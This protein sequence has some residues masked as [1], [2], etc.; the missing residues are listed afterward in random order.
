VTALLMATAPYLVWY[1]QEAKM[2][3]ALTVLVPAALLLTV[4]VARRG[5]WWRWVLLYVI[6]SLAFYTHL[7]AALVVPIQALWLLLL[8]IASASG[9]AQTRADLGGQM[10]LRRGLA[11]AGYLSA[12]LLPY[13][14]L[15]MW[16]TRAWLGPAWETGFSFVSLPNILLVLAV[17]FSRG[18]LP[19]SQPITLLPYMLAGVAGVGLWTAGRVPYVWRPTQWQ[20]IGILSIWL[21]LPPLALF[22]IS[23][24][25]PIFTDRYLI[26]AM[27]AWL[28]LAGLGVVALAKVWRPLGL[29]TLAAILA[30]NAVSIGAQ[31]R[32]MIKSDFRAAAQY[33][34][35]NR[36]PDDLL[37]YQI[38]HS[39]YT[40]TYYSSGRGDPETGAWR[41][42]DG[43][44]T[45]N[46]MDEAEAADRMATGMTGAGAVWLIASEAP[47]WDVRGLTEG[48]LAAHGTVTH[49]AEFARVTVTRYQLVR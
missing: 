21:L 29:A 48:W 49:H 8:P 32:Q 16:Q 34:A 1:G 7:L 35:T 11:V 18:V 41:G 27:P 28:A 31:A 37:V 3:A 24:K 22:G 2:Y 5:G 20:T 44:Y 4:E 43:L 19:V 6:T 14:P 15:L 40:F 39:R 38:P 17:A 9:V 47:M 30:L 45:N 10:R 26:W 13:L 42:F 12:L 33:V 36:Q 46:G 25:A 23:F